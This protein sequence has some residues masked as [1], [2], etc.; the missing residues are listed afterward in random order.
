MLIAATT[1]F[2]YYTTWTLLMVSTGL[3]TSATCSRSASSKAMAC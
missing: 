3:L 1:V 2:V